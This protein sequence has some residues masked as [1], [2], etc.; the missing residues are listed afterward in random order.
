MDSFAL[1]GGTSLALRFGHRISVDLDFL[2]L[3]NRNL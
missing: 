3:F 1:A 2:P